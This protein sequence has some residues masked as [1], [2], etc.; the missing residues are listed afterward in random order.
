MKAM[1]ATVN[2]PKAQK[3]YEELDELLENPPFFDKTV[4]SA[5]VDELFALVEGK[6]N[7]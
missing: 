6:R 3:L 7:E 1:L 5:K 4:F 2:L